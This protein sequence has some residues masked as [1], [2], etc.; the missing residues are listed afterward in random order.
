MAFN[1]PTLPALIDRIQ[2]DIESRLPGTDPRLRR[3][4]LFAIVR[5]IAGAVHGLYG[6]LAWMARQ[7]IPSTA[8]ANYLE[9][10]AS[11]WGIGRKPAAPAVGIVDFTGTDGA[12]IPAGTTLQR[13]DSVEYTTDAEGTITGS[14]AEIAVTAVEGG[15]DTNADPGVTLSLVSP[16][17]GVYSTATV[18]VAGDGLTGGADEEGDD[19]LRDRLKARVQR[20]PQGG[21]IADY[22]AWALEVE[23][24]TRAWVMPA[25]AGLGT[26]GVFFVRDDDALIIPDAAEV[27]A[28]QDYLDTVRPVTADVTAYAPTVEPVDM[29]IQLAPNTLDV[30]AAVEASLTDLFRREA[31]VEDGN[32]SGAIPISHIREAISGA[33]GEI[34]HVLIS[35]SG[36]VAPSLGALATLG[37][38]TWQAIS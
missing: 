3:S 14:V 25:W 33:E 8:D 26:V 37:V 38:I 15:Q 5:A 30:Q 21:A 2:S 19:S 6:F 10:H 28:V 12:V 9:R 34:D 23:G 36:D 18:S 13:A 7:I 20:S 22:E 4:V 11:W 35:P 27:Q 31:N 1:R 29:T 24:V 17:S 32:G 16:I